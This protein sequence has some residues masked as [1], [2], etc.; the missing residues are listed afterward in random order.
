MFASPSS[1]Y[2]PCPQNTFARTPAAPNPRVIS[3]CG[4]TPRFTV[5][6]PQFSPL[7]IC[8]VGVVLASLTKNSRNFVYPERLSR[9]ATLAPLFAT[10]CKEQNVS[11]IFPIASAL[12]AQNSR[13][14][15][16]ASHSG[17]R[18][19]SVKCHG[20][21]FTSSVLTILALVLSLTDDCGLMT[22]DCLHT[23][24]YFLNRSIGVRRPGH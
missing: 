9:G 17:T 2:S 16:N 19:F 23:D 24:D 8:G 5:F 22:D 15:P 11:P 13:V 21:F 4:Q 3:T 18:P 14:S 20:I 6:W 1:S 12:F 7:T 10:L